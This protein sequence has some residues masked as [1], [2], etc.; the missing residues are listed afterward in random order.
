MLFYSGN[1]LLSH[2]NV[3]RIDKNMMGLTY[4]KSYSNIYDHMCCNMGTPS[5]SVAWLLLKKNMV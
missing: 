3:L 5:M 1:V 2:Q 4:F